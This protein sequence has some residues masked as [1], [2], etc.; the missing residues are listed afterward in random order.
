[1]KQRRSSPVASMLLFTIGPYLLFSSC[2]HAVVASTDRQASTSIRGQQDESNAIYD[3]RA[4]TMTA[5]NDFDA[6]TL[7]PLGKDSQNYSEE[8]SAA[9]RRDLVSCR[10]T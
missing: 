9:R 6:A 10:V 7:S 4:D 5:K 1:M 2:S 3:R 8:H